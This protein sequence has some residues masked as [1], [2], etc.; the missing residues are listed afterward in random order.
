MIRFIIAVL[1]ITVFF[2]FSIIL[3]PIYFIIG[4]F[5]INL[6]HRI[7]LVTI[8]WVF[9]VIS[10]IAGA[11]VDVKGREKVPEGPVLYVANHRSVFDIIIGYTIV[12]RITGFI[13]K[14]EVKKYPFLSW[15][16][17]FMNCLFLDRSNVREG[18]KTILKAIEMEK[19]GISIFIFPEG[20]RSKDGSVA[21][22]KG[23]SFKIAEKAKVPIVPIAITD[24]EKIF[25]NHKPSLKPTRVTFEFCEPIYMDKLDKEEKKLVAKMARDEI[26]KKVE[27]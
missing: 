11:K 13:S 9:R 17:Y 7:S 21:E 6:R 23:G 22:F 16:M 1:F 26:A 19:S 8:Q 18:L 14:Q 3:Y 20:T 12:D 27:K 10:F 24:T 5:N 2:I 15:W 4:K 25:E